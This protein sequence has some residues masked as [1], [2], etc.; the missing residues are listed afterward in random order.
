MRVR[1]S[2]AACSAESFF[3]L[4]AIVFDELPSDPG[5]LCADVGENG[6]HDHERFIIHIGMV[7]GRCTLDKWLFQTRFVQTQTE[8]SWPRQRVRSNQP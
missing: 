1:S 5:Y 2:H 3:F 6:H 7:P 4:F 8:S